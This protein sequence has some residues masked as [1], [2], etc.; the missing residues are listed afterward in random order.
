MKM[1]VLALLAVVVLTLVC[2]QG[3]IFLYGANPELARF[4]L[5]EGGPDRWIANM[6]VVGLLPPA[7][8]V[9]V[10]RRVGYAAWVTTVVVLTYAWQ[11]VAG[12][13]F[14]GPLDRMIVMTIIGWTLAAIVVFAAR[15]AS[16]TVWIVAGLIL[17]VPLSL[18][19]STLLQIAHTLPQPLA[20]PGTLLSLLVFPLAFVVGALLLYSALKPYKQWEM[21]HTVPSGAVGESRLQTGRIIVVCVG[22]GVIL[23]VKLMHTFYWF[24]VWDTTNDPLGNFLLFLPVVTVLFCGAM[25]FFLLPGRTRLAGPSYLL[26][27]PVLLALSTWAQSVDF[28]VLTNERAE[29][30]SQTINAYHTR[31]GR[32][33]QDLQQLIPFYF[34]SLPGPV[35]MFGEEGW[36]YYGGQDFYR[37]GYLDRDHWSSPIVFGR[38]YS[39]QGDP[40]LKVD[41]CQSALAAYRRER[42]DYERTLHQYGRPTPT[43][44]LR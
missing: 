25:L 6:I 38:L 31:E 27:L 5:G 33:P 10:T 37:F 44:D 29:Q 43:P 19:D 41:V 30:V 15:R 35:I 16:P 39:F 40:P 14:G 3:P 26:F 18:P 17:L 23:L 1:K 7:M 8:V 9:L 42:P 12:L 11:N 24:M 32:Y 28:R 34:L 2:W 22:V 21:A 13:M 20:D 4:L 36:C